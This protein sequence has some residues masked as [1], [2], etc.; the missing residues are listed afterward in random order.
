[1]ELLKLGKA[2]VTRAS[3][4]EPHQTRAGWIADM[5]PSDGPVLGANGQIDRDDFR[6]GLVNDA[7]WARLEPFAT[8]Q[9]AL[10]AE[11]RWLAEH[12]GL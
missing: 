4:V 3:H 7:L 12:R 11:R 1:M 8:R 10:D 6:A 9:E 2:T 5:L